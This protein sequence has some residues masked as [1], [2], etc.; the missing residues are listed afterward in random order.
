VQP[1]ALSDE[2]RIFLLNPSQNLRFPVVLG[3]AARRTTSSVLSAE[4]R[5]RELQ[6]ARQQ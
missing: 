5:D 6:I 3:M 2:H 1:V 4:D